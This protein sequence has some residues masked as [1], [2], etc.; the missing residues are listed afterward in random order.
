M[1]KEELKE[2]IDSLLD[3]AEEENE[4]GGSETSDG[5]LMPGNVDWKQLRANILEAV[6]SLANP[7]N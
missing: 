7:S 5:V 1:T 2:T 4:W 6:D 3:D